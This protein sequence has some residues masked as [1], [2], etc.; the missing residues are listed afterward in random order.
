MTV[1]KCSTKYQANRMNNE[2]IVDDVVEHE[3]VYSYDSDD[4]FSTTQCE[5]CGVKK[6][7]EV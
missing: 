7:P 1:P 6:H 3:W 4:G 2:W 5:Y